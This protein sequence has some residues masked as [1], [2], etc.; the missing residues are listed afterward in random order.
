MLAQSAL[1]HTGERGALGSWQ[2]STLQRKH[3]IAWF[4]SRGG[5][6]AVSPAPRRPSHL[7]APFNDQ[8]LCVSLEYREEQ[9]AKTYEVRDEELIDLSAE[10]HS[11]EQLLTVLRASKPDPNKD[12]KK[13]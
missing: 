8:T 10:K 2:L 3:G 1:K 4:P 6:L 12:D 13:H 7:A 11:L 5:R 9:K